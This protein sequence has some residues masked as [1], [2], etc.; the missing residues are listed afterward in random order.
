MQPHHATAIDSSYTSMSMAVLMVAKCSHLHLSSLILLS[1]PMNLAGTTQH[2]EQDHFALK[3]LSDYVLLALSGCFR[4]PNSGTFSN[5][6]IAMKQV[7]LA[8]QT[9]GFTTHS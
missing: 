5:N 3:N 2:W 9:L 8:M 1:S 6:T 4:L 7:H